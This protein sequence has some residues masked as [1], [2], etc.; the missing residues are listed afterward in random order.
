M[1]MNR[2]HILQETQTHNLTTS[3]SI[4]LLPAE[5]ED[6]MLLNQPVFFSSQQNLSL[7]PLLDQSVLTTTASVTQNTTE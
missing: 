4:L 1:F 2:G 6:I 5:G 3:V 7:F